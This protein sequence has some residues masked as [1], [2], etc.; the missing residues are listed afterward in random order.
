MNQKQIADLR[1]LFSSMSKDE[2]Q[3]AKALIVQETEQRSEQRRKEL[4]GNLVAAIE[5]YQREIGPISIYDEDEY[6]YSI[7]G[8]EPGVIYIHV[9]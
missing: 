2:L 3:S 1:A 8:M 5:K 9:D 4:W 7:D 6:K